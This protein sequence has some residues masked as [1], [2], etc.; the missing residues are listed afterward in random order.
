M[1][2]ADLLSQ[3]SS[4]GDFLWSLMQYWTSISVGILIAS[5]FVASRLNGFILAIF[6]IIYTVFTVQIVTLMQLELQAIKGIFMD[7]EIMAGKG[8]ALSNTA[9]QI[10]EHSPVANDTLIN[11]LFRLVMTGGMFLIT[12]SYPIYCKRRA[13]S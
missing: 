12:I 3:L 2:E 6:I 7:L 10:L 8:V 5:H 13:E 4:F 11:Q 9:R 1:T